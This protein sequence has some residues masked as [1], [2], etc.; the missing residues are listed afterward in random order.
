[1]RRVGSETFLSSEASSD[2]DWSLAAAFAVAVASDRL[3]GSPK[4]G[5]VLVGHS[6]GEI[7]AL[8]AAGVFDLATGVRVV[9]SRAQALRENAAESGGM[10]AFD[11]GLRRA[12]AMIDTLGDP[13]VAVAAVNAPRSTV[14][15]GPLASLERLADAASAL[16][17]HSA[18]VNA[19]YP[20]HSPLLREAAAQFASKIEGIPV[21]R[22]SALL[23]SPTESRFYQDGDD[24]VSL[25]STHLFRPVR[26]MDAIRELYASGYDEFTECSPEAMLSHLAERTIPNV[27]TGVVAADATR[28]EASPPQISDRVPEPREDSQERPAKATPEPGASADGQAAGGRAA[29]LAELRKF[30]AGELGYPEDVV[31]EDADLEAELGVDS[32]QQTELFVRIAA[33]YRLGE[34]GKGVNISEYP[35]LGALVDFIVRKSDRAEAGAE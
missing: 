30:Y 25:L 29:I 34:A 32:I 9:C 35:T 20:F 1:M 19:P 16:D 12:Q 2:P 26:F 15:S 23:Y 8:V 31:S 21:G 3:L 33:R 5:D 17:I 4:P 24:Y 14:V 22:P 13:M 28:V 7:A 11:V 6:G 18:R 27:I 10:R